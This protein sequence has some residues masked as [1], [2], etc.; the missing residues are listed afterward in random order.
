MMPGRGPPVAGSGA[1]LA[2]WRAL[3]ALA[4]GLHPTQLTPGTAL[5]PSLP[6]AL[7]VRVFCSCDGSEVDS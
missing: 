3:W 1:G 7:G 5:A 4:V 2:G 6:G